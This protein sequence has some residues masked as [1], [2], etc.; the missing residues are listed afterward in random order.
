MGFVFS[1]DPDS[2]PSCVVRA[3]DVFLVVVA[4]IGHFFGGRFESCCHCV[5]DYW[6]GFVVFDVS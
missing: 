5:E 2:F 4:D 3:L 1:V 6:V